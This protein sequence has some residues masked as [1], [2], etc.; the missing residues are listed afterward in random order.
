MKLISLIKKACTST[1][2]EELQ[3]ML[4]MHKEEEEE[5]STGDIVKANQVMIFHKL[6]ASREIATEIV[7]FE[8]ARNLVKIEDEVNQAPQAACFQ[9]SS[10]DTSQMEIAVKII[11]F[12]NARNLIKVVDDVDQ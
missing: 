1:I 9:E 10:L 2:R 11:S 6:P 5:W 3:V 7:C 8:N 4:C 12:E